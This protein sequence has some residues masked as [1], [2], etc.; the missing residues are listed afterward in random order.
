MIHNLDGPDTSPSY[1]SWIMRPTEN[2]FKPN[3]RVAEISDG[4][5]NT[6]AISETIQGKGGDL[7]GFGWWGGGTHFETLLTPN[8]P[9]PDRTEQSCTPADALNPP[10][11]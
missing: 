6:L 11:R 5:S 4:T 3:T 2:T 7:R 8:S 1:Y 10:C 9:L